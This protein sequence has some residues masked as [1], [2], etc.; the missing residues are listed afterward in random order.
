[1]H[2]HGQRRIAAGIGGALFQLR[3]VRL[4]IEAGVEA[5]RSRVRRIAWAESV[6]TANQLF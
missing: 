4:H 2:I 1:M 6:E 5:I 3:I